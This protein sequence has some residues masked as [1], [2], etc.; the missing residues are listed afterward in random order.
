MNVSEKVDVANHYLASASDSMIHDS[1]NTDN[2]AGILST[3]NSALA[4]EE[5]LFLSEPHIYIFTLGKVLVFGILL[6]R[7][8]GI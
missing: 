2:L 8:S 7:E 6:G 4:Y 5:S 1:I 3:I